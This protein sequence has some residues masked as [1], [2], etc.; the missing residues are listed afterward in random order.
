MPEQED[1]MP[2]IFLSDW[3]SP[4]SRK[5]NP[6]IN[7]P[8]HMES[9]TIHNVVSYAIEAKTCGTFKN[10]KAAIGMIPNLITLDHEQPAIPLKTDNSKTEGFVNLGMKPKRSKTWDMK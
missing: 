4:S 3:P 5:P 7:G 10:L 9:K 2:V 6:K 1:V 8:I